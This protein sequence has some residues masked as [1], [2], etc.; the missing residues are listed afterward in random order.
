[1]PRRLRETAGGIVYHVLNRAVGKMDLFRK[2]A[3]YT[4]FEKVLEETWERFDV[5]ILSYCLMPTQRFALTGCGNF[6]FLGSAGSISFLTIL[7]E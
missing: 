4:A 2:D 1:M 3:D 5:R 6:S 7:S